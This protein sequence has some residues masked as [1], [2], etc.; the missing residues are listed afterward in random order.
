MSFPHDT[1]DCDELSQGTNAFSYSVS[2]G[3]EGHALPARGIQHNLTTDLDSCTAASASPVDL[4]ETASTM[5]DVLDAQA[6]IATRNAEVALEGSFAILKHAA[7]QLRDV[8]ADLFVLDQNLGETFESLAAMQR[9]L[10]VLSAGEK[11]LSRAW[12]THQ[13]L[14]HEHAGLFKE[15]KSKLEGDIAILQAEHNDMQKIRRSIVAVRHQ[16][17]LSLESAQR[18]HAA[19]IK[20]VEQIRQFI[21]EAW[22]AYAISFDSRTVRPHYVARAPGHKL[23]TLEYVT[24]EY[25]RLSSVLHEGLVRDEEEEVLHRTKRRLK[26]TG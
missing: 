14:F 7:Y 13:Y 10:V 3:V 4:A 18:T 20:T 25:D 1:D 24:D 11:Q 8:L 22:T 26:S 16:K 12:Q 19:N 2:S 17:E 6:S 21:V 23:S 9:E 15:R 5:I